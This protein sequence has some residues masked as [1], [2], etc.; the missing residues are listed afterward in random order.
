MRLP[1]RPVADAGEAIT[2]R[3]ITEPV[4]LCLP[5]GRLNPAAVGWTRSPVHRANLRGW[6]RNKRFEYWSISTPDAV[7]TLNI[8]DHDYRANVA[9]T[10]G[11]R[12]E[13]REIR[14]GGNIW[15]PRH[16]G[17]RDPDN[18]T[19]MR[20]QR[21]DTTVEFVPR[22]RG[23]ELYAT[24]PRI[25]VALRVQAEAD[26]E[27]M[28]VVV[29][30]SNRLFQYTRKDNGLSATGT[31]TVDGVEHRVEADSSMVIHDHGRGR[32]PYFTFWNWASGNGTTTDGRRLG[33]QFGGKW[34]DGTPSTENSIRLDGV[35]HKISEHLRWQYDPG[36]WLRPW[37]L[38]GPTV[39]VEFVPTK[40]VHHVFNRWI[41]LNRADMCFGRFS[42]TVDIDG[43]RISFSGVPGHAE[44]VQRR[45]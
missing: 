5:S 26:H 30:W 15:L 45:W 31:V 8:S 9:V 3:E 27:S 19:P 42:G 39:R 36:D 25:R 2:E 37:T 7:I 23:S 18:A 24:S 33:L 6:G 13:D 16:V 43:D 40:H 34:T 17:M 35:L 21:R 14:Q 11:S 41:V 20:A 38:T 44:E 28:G 12:T 1:I 10:Y 4:D 32:W 22:G 29:P